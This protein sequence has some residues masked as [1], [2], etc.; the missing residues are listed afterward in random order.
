MSA[1]STFKLEQ[2]TQPLY[3]SNKTYILVVLDPATTTRFGFQ[4]RHYQAV[5]KAIETWTCIC[6]LHH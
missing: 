6:V 4:I 2:S 1:S 3:S 5:N